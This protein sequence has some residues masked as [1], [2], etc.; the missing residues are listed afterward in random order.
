MTAP[1]HKDLT[2][3][4][5]KELLNYDPE[6]GDFTWKVSRG[7]NAIAGSKAGCA[8]KDGYVV[9]R[10]N[11]IGYLAHRLAWLYVHGRFPEKLIDHIDQN[12]YNNRISNL[13]EA[14]L[15]LNA[16]NCSAANG[17]TGHRGVY[18]H[19]VVNRYY[20]QISLGGKNKHLG[21][22]DTLEQAI[23]ARV[24]AV[25]DYEEQLLAA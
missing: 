22:F 16:L 25:K 4:Q 6:T 12:G 10:L 15:S 21:M 1:K 23:A 20:A 7:R 2:Q 19:T 9:I 17:K 24:K 3:A 18:L 11:G 5:L 8:K 13:R 14:C